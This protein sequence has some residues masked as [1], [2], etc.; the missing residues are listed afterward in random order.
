M[1]WSRGLVTVALATFV[2]AA[3][4]GASAPCPMDFARQIPPR[5][6]DAM[7]GSE[8]VRSVDGIGGRER[9]RLIVRELLAGNLPSFL[10][11]LREVRLEEKGL[12]LDARVCVMPDYL[13]IGSDR[14][15]VRVPM[16]RSAAAAVA[17]RFGFLMPTRKLVDD[18]YAASDVRLRPRPMTPGRL[19]TSVTYF[20]EHNAFIEQ[21]RSGFP[22]GAL[23]AGHKKDVVLSNRLARHPGRVA[24]YGW[25]RPDGRAIQPLSTVHGRDYAD[26]SHGVRLVSDRMWI[27]GQP[28]SVYEVLADP[29]LAPVLTFEGRIPLAVRLLEDPARNFLAATTGTTASSGGVGTN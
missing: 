21:Q 25:Q 15:Y 18:I 6:P 24:I 7:S 19:M 5:S 26:Y 27:D 12:G 28:R 10:R 4:A 22:L 20:R 23:M 1:K 8:F 13:A 2:Y 9:D 11:A 29:K 16:G 17:L 3:Q 14:D